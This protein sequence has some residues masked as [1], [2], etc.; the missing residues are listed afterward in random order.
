M[1]SHVF[2]S[3]QDLLW[4]FAVVCL[5]VWLLRSALIR[6]VGDSDGSKV[7]VQALDEACR[8]P[9][10]S[11]ASEAE[12]YGH[13]K[14]CNAP[15]VGPRGVSFRANDPEPFEYDSG[16]CYGHYIGLHKPTDDR[17]RNES[18]EYPYAD[19]MHGRRRLWEFRI[20]MK[21]R[22]PVSGELCWSM[23]QDRYYKVSRVQKMTANTL[24]A[25]VRKAVPGLYQTFGEDPTTTV[26]EA[27]RP[28]NVVPLS[29]MDQLIFTPAGETPPD[30]CDRRFST[31]GLIKADNRAAMTRAVKA[32]EFIPGPTF[33]FAFWCVSPYVDAIKWAAPSRAFLPAISFR[34]AGV[35]PPA[36]L[37]IYKLQ[38]ANNPKE[39]RHLD[40]RKQY[41]W[42]VC[43]WSSL[44]PPDPDRV[45]EILDGDAGS[46]KA[47]AA[48]QDR[49]RLKS[50]RCCG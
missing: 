30:L 25:A 21:F 46:A 22:Y 43:L 28:A 41:L 39:S 4:G 7:K 17:E 45:R 33:T 15:P 10:D 16:T 14:L 37:S 49:G 20:Q 8:Q 6:Q 19:H 40:S 9:D 18:G 11:D 26:G 31:L 44:H 34:D 5:I 12:Q 1:L 27:E 24:M 35:H 38:P 48:S 29:Q 32:L 23:E 47:R 3:T 42:R 2:T 50:R 36:Y 13:I